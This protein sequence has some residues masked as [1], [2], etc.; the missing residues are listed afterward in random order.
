MSATEQIRPDANEDQET[1]RIVRE[2]MAAFEKDRTTVD[3]REA[4]TRLQQKLTQQQPR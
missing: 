2:R 4:I 3:P 1:E